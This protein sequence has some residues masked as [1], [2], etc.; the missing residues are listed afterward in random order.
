MRTVRPGQQLTGHREWASGGLA[1]RRPASDR[2]DER[3]R[4][5]VSRW[6]VG[7]RA[8]CGHGRVRA[9]AGAGPGREDQPAAP[10][11]RASPGPCR[12]RRMAIPICRAT[13]PTRRSRRSSGMGNRPR[14]STKEEAAAIEDRE[15]GGGAESATRRA[16]RIAAP[17]GG[18][19]RSAKS[20]RRA[21]VLELLWRAAA[22]R[23][24]ATTRSG[25]IRATGCCAS[26]AQPRSSII[27]DPPNGR[28]PGLHR[29]GARA[30][31]EGRR[32]RQEQ[33]SE[34]DHPELRPLAE[35][36]ITSFG[37][38]AG[39]PMLPN[40]FYNNSYTIVQTQGHGDD[41][42]R[43]GAR[44]AH[45]PHGRHASACREHAQ[46][47]RRFDRPLG[48]RHAGHRDDQL[49]SDPARQSGLPHGMAR[50]RT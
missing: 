5:L 38:N 35:R 37:N 40:Y 18:G 17:P 24:A 11:A 36:C 10:A 9:A 6:H 46:V 2:G 19:E 44:R 28:V 7:H 31:G 45:R 42:H 29:R 14:R 3:S 50:G 12:A 33:G 22:A 32:G 47:V 23:S 30:D 26:T 39:P 43:D 8:R 1:G 20:P 21:D 25:S 49:P 48:R 13:G 27:I 34:F 41:P 15:Q 16:I 4:T